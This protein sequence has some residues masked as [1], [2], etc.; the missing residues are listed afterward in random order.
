MDRL[1]RFDMYPH[2]WLIDTSRLEPVDGWVYTQVVMLIYQN[3]K[4]IPDDAKWIAG[5]CNVSSRAVRGAVD[6]LVDNGFIQKT[7]DK[8]LTQKRAEKELNNKRTHLER[9]LNGGR[10]SAESRAQSNKNNDMT[11]SGDTIPVPTPSP[12]PSPLS[13]RLNTPLPPT[14]KIT[15]PLAVG[16][17]KMFEEGRVGGA[18]VSREAQV[19][20]IERWLDDHA[21][22]RA[23]DAM[24]SGWNIQNLIAVYNEGVRN[25]KRP[26]PKHPV[27]AF[28]AWIPKYTNGAPPR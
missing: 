20:N 18:N 23:L 27:A 22:Q 24:P 12:H 2:D 1:F 17:L 28:C 4:P 9:S 14:D 13:Y 26:V 8:K 21:R 19:F 3:R 7:S 5:F 15:P 6:R 11:S 10:K 16:V 25:G